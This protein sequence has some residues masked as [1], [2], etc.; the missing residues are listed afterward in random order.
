MVIFAT[1]Q[2]ECKSVFVDDKLVKKKKKVH[3][4]EFCFSK[5]GC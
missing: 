1:I 5:A 4:S 3:D 2:K